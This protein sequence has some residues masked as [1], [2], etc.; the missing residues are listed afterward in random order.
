MHEPER[1]RLLGR[2]KRKYKTILTH[3]AP[4]MAVAQGFKW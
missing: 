3:L 2:A 4:N 1:K